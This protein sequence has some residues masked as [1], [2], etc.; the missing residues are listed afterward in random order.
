MLSLFDTAA[1]RARPVEFRE[2]GHATMYV[3]GPT[4]YGPPHLGHGRFSLVFDILRRYLEWSG[5]EVTYVSNITDIDDQ[6]INKGEAEGRDP[7]E[8]AVEFE[9]KWYEGMD[10]IGV[11]RPTFDPHATAYVDQ[12][13]Q[14]IADLIAADRAYETSD[15]VYLATEGIEGY[16]TLARQSLDSLRSGARVEV[17]DEKHSPLDFVLWKKAKPGEPT[18]DSPWGPGRPGW[19]TECVVM[20]L[21]LLGEGFDIH[22]GGQDLAFPHHENE[23]AQAKALG[24]AFARHWVHNGFVEVAG[25]KMSKSLGNYTDLLDLATSADPRAYR[26]LVLQAHYRSPVEVNRETAAAA[27][28]ALATFDALARRMVGVDPGEADEAELDRFRSLM[29]D[30]MD[31]PAVVAQLFGLATSANTALDGG[32]PASAA[33]AW[34]TIGEITRAVG[35]DIKAAGGEVPTEITALAAER[36]EARAAKDFARADALRDELKSLGWEV[37]DTPEGTRVHLA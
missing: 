37:E 7:A 33:T 24:K 8:V 22:G 25:E 6:I 30:D 4:V 23:W 2:P 31:T 18:W 3:C 36:D 17:N 35:I 26:L 28:A 34:A 14:L 12:M 16:G 11:E 20:S 1:G 10:L 27:S 21:E 15:G 29:D 9:A 5:L 19:H 32:D 13:V